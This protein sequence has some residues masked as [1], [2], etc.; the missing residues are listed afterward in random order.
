[1]L[2]FFLSRYKSRDILKKAIRVTRKWVSRTAGSS[3]SES[4]GPDSESD[5]ESNSESL[6]PDIPDSHPGL[7]PSHLILILS[8]VRA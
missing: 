1:M 2:I 6:G 7:I 3:V 5:S 8:H 4:P